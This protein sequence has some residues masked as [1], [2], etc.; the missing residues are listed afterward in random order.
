MS[1]PRDP[2]RGTAIDLNLSSQDPVGRPRGEGTR[3][4]FTEPLLVGKPNPV[5]RERLLARLDG[6]LDR[7]RFSND[8]PLVREFEST[9]ASVVGVAHAVAMCNA[10]VAMEV[11]GRALALQGE[12]IVPAFTFVA[13]AHALRWL[14]LVPVFA[15]IDPT[16]H[17]LDPDRLESLISPRTSA[18]VGVHLWGRS[19]ETDAIEAIAARHGLPVIYDA[20]HAFACSKGDRMIGG[21]G[22]CEIFS[23]HATKFVHSFEGG[24]VTTNDDA[25]AARL[26]LMRNFGFAGLDSI[27]SLGTNAKMSEVHAAMGL[28]SLDGMDA[29]LAA[30]TANRN[31]YRSGLLGIDG[32]S[33]LEFP[34]TDRNNHQYVVIEID[35]ASFGATRDHLVEHLREQGVLARRYFT[36]PL[37]RVPPYCCSA[38]SESGPLPQAELVAARVA[39]LPTGCQLGPDDA[40]A[41]CELVRQLGATSRRGRRST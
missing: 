14:G 34:A 16:T 10:T 33:L 31:A 39:V 6:M 19:C 24:V 25:L 7:Q 23:F 4:A 20:A 15:D 9:V 38:A 30:N 22:T 17:N 2:E 32:I 37:H 29:A 41:I 11:V 1:D 36:P 27:V 18:I 26:R 8:G 35:S 21:F 3:P 28:T 40:S 12:V 13:T 5:D